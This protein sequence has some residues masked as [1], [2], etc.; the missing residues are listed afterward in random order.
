MRSDPGPSDRTY[1]E[2]RETEKTPK[3][4]T[5]RVMGLTQGG[6]KHPTLGLGLILT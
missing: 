6:Y 3:P 5:P 4:V 1:L 2:E